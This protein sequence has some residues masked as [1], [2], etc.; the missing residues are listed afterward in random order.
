MSTELGATHIGL[1]FYPPSP[2]CLTTAQAQDI[3]AALRQCPQKPVIV[4]VFVNM[5]VTDIQTLLETVDMD[6]AQLNGDEPDSDLLTLGDRGFRALRLRPGEET[7]PLM[8]RDTPAFLIDSRVK[9]EYGGTGHTADWDAAA[10]LAANYNLFLAGGI[11]PLNV[12]EAVEKVRPWGIDLASGV[13]STPGVKDPAKIKALMSEIQ[14][15]A[16]T[17]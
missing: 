6:L 4:G 15:V 1:N 3:A 13:E 16:N 14:R 11:T 10:T 12:A 17:N 7:V 5:P 9:G 8:T 2:R